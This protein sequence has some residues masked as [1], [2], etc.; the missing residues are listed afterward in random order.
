MSSDSSNSMPRVES[1]E[2]VLINLDTMDWSVVPGGEACCKE[3]RSYWAYIFG[4]GR[5]ALISLEIALEPA[6]LGYLAA[7]STTITYDHNIDLIITIVWV[8]IPYNYE[9][10]PKFTQ[11][12]AFYAAL[13][14]NH[15]PNIYI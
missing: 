7:A 14:A 5:K 6:V 2:R 1:S 8:I 3:E 11:C 12:Y 4:S 10:T 9:K 13:H 15:V